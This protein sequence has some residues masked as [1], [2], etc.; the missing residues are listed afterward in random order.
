MGTNKNHAQISEFSFLILP[1]NLHHFRHV[2]GLYP[3]MEKLGPI[4]IVHKG[5]LR[6]ENMYVEVSY[7]I[8]KKKITCYINIV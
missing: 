6:D 7:P 1:I 4:S 2:R 8:N 3:T 5:S